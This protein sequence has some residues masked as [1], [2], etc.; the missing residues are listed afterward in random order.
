[1]LVIHDGSDT[2]VGMDQANRL[3]ADYAGPA[4]LLVTDRLGHQRI[5]IARE[6]VQAVVEFVDETPSPASLALAPEADD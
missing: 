6:V 2:T 3:I 5:L 1:M 4:R